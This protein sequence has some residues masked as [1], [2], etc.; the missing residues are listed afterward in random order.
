MAAASIPV[1]GIRRRGE[2]FDANTLPPVDLIDHIE[3]VKDGASTVYGA[4]AV[5]GVINIITKSPEKVSGQ[6]PCG[7]RLLGQPAVGL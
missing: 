2:T 1:W 3:I 4:D 5:G 6:G 7:L